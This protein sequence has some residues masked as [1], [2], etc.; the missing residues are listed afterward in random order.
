MF[1]KRRE[2]EGFLQWAVRFR[3]VNILLQEANI[4]EAYTLMNSI[5]RSAPLAQPRMPAFHLLVCGLTIHFDQGQNDWE[6]LKTCGKCTTKAILDSQ[7]GHNGLDPENRGLRVS[8][9]KESGPRHFWSHD[10]KLSTYGWLRAFHLC[11]ARFEAEATF[12]NT[13]IPFTLNGVFYTRKEED[14]EKEVYE[15]LAS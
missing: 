7:C 5:L 3:N 12:A 10:D 8:G 9:I 15:R 13:D 11:N 6:V 2:D 1:V 4:P 14:D